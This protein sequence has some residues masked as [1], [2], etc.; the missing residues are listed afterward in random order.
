MTIRMI[1]MSNE[2]LDAL[3]LDAHDEPT[4]VNKT[5]MKY[6]T[7]LGDEGLAGLE[8]AV[9]EYG[10]AGKHPVTGKIT[11]PT[12]EV[13]TILTDGS[14]DR[15]YLSFNETGKDDHPDYSTRKVADLD[16]LI[17]VLQNARYAADKAISEREVPGD[18]PSFDTANAD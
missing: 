7:F 16:T 6:R 13:T 14:G 8:V 11:H 9:E 5:H 3:D 17:A 2:L 15:V 1:P 10:W 18:E 12:V 4:Y